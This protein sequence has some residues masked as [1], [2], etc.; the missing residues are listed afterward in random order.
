MRTDD[1]L[2]LEDGEN[3]KIRKCEEERWELSVTERA[4]GR[5][6]DGETGR[7][8]ENEKM[9]PIRELKGSNPKSKI[10]FL[11]SICIICVI[12]G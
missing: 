11:D 7:R 8:W 9:R 2:R 12:C 1:D 10:K 6:R 4:R 5:L 3:V